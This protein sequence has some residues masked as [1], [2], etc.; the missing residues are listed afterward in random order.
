MRFFTNSS[1]WSPWK[2]W[3]Q[4]CEWR[5]TLVYV[6]PT[7]CHLPSTWT[8]QTWQQWFTTRLLSE[9]LTFQQEWGR[10]RACRSSRWRGLGNAKCCAPPA[11]GAWK[12]SSRRI[13]ML[14]MNII[15][16]LCDSRHRMN[17][18]LPLVTR[19]WDRSW[20]FAWSFRFRALSS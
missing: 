13:R 7:R 17:E 16:W 10:R 14:P 12:R 6:E 15:S 3:V 4:Q 5:L 20:S 11:C 8:T 9:W 1:H 18:Q 19:K 2:H